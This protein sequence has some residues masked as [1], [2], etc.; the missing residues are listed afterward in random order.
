MRDFLRWLFNK[1]PTEVERLTKELEELKEQ[2]E[3]VCEENEHFRK[4]LELKK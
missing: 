2:Y 1:S 4:Q 3:S